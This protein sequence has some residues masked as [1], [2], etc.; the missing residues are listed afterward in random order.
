MLCS[1]GPAYRG[2]ERTGH[3]VVRLRQGPVSAA[4]P[5]HQAAGEAAAA[6]KEPHAAEPPGS[7]PGRQSVA[8]WKSAE[9]LVHTGG[10]GAREGR[11]GGG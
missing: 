5:V 8:L 6:H 11:A 2:A 9:L 4:L 10:R 3:G 7:G 1:L